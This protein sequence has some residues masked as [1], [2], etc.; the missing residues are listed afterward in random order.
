MTQVERD[1]TRLASIVLLP[2]IAIGLLAGI[3][4]FGLR[5]GFDGGVDRMIK[6]FKR[7]DSA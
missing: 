5:A 7:R 4:V 3:I 1:E 2:F 6:I